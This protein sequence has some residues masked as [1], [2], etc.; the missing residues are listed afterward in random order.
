M[1]KIALLALLTSLILPVALLAAGPVLSDSGSLRAQLPAGLCL[2]CKWKFGLRAHYHS[3]PSFAVMHGDGWGDGFHL[4]W[5]PGNCDV[6]HGLCVVILT[7]AH[8]LTKEISDA[9]AANDIESLVKFAALPSV[10]LFADRS[11]IQVLG[12]D[13]KTIAG[14][15][16]ADQ[17]LLDEIEAATGEILDLD[18]DA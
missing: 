18:P 16:P 15:V 12:C 2:N 8:E 3:T 6:V 14:H 9:V 1:R 4:D 13:G 7:D 11:A 5:R 10:N 17:T